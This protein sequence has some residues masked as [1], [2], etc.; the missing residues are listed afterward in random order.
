[1]ILSAIYAALFIIIIHLTPY[2]FLS[3]IVPY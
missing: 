1:M 3:V 2:H